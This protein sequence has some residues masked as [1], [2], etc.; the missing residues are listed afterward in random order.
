F[1]NGCKFSEDKQIKVNILFTDQNI[2][3][4]FLDNGIGI[5]EEDLRHVFLPFYRGRNKTFIDGN[6][7]GMP[8]TQKIILLHQGSISVKSIINIG[9]VFTVHLP[10]QSKK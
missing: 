2:I 10:N 7:I 8:L 4:N 5:P 3:L 1:E 9:T 6:G